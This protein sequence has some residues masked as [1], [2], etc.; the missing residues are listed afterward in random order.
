MNNVEWRIPTRKELLSIFKTRRDEYV[1]V[2]SPDFY[3]SHVTK[4]WSSSVDLAGSSNAWNVGFIGGYEVWNNK[5]S[6]YRVR[7]VRIVKGHLE[8][9]PDIK[10]LNW[11][12]A[13]KYAKGLDTAVVSIGTTTKRVVILDPQSG[14]VTVANFE[15][16]KDRNMEKQIE[17]QLDIN[18]INKKWMEA[19]HLDIQI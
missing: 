12:Q 16:S 11:N 13:I 10:T 18:L 15:Y 9:H 4:F 7:C 8:F 3:S 1:E 2:C 17:E 14:L 6:K 19:I 5:G